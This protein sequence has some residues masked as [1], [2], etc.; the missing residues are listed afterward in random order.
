M[1]GWLHRLEVG[2]TQK[3]VQRKRPEPELSNESHDHQSSSEKE[4]LC[5]SELLT[6]G[7]GSSLGGKRIR[8]VLGVWS[9]ISLAATSFERCCRESRAR[10]WEA[11]TQSDTACRLGMELS[12]G[13]DIDLAG[14]ADWEGELNTRRRM[15]LSCGKLGMRMVNGGRFS[16]TRRLGWKGDFIP[17][18]GG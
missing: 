11:A 15:G 13:E 17:I 5:E 14:E 2:S 4:M 9:A 3:V 7:R 6:Y 8:R 1:L 18:V 16:R 10:R 12:A